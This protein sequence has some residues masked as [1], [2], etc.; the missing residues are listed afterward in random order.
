MP[1]ISGSS[2]GSGI[3]AVLLALSTLEYLAQ[4]RSAVGVT[5]LAQAFDTT[6]SRMH[7]HLQTLV[8]AGYILQDQSSDR[9]RVSARLMALGEAVSENFELS[10]AARSVMHELRDSLS[11]AVAVSSPEAD[12]VRIVSVLRGRSNVEIGVKPGSLLRFHD[13]AQGKAALA[14]GDPA[15][16]RGVLGRKLTASTPHTITDP[17]KLAAEVERIKECGWSTSPNETVIGLNAL[18]A[19]V[20]GAL[21]RY[22]GAIAIVDLVQFLPEVPTDEQIRRVSAAAA[23]ISEY[24]GYRPGN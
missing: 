23:Q 24:L 13:S 1:R 5:E 22:V 6:K 17:A 12:G 4:R 10:D 7:R 15:V 9:Y 14:F 20:F 3:Q 18:A 11:H 16:L 2:H 19:P 21:G 8:S